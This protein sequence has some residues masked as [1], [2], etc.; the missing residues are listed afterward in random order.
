VATSARQR[1]S[2]VSADLVGLGTFWNEDATSGSRK[3]R[4]QRRDRQRFS[5][6]LAQSGRNFGR[7]SERCVHEQ[8][9][10]VWRAGYVTRAVGSATGRVTTCHG[11]YGRHDAGH[12]QRRVTAPG[13]AGHRAGHGIY[14]AGDSDHGDGERPAGP[15]SG[16][17]GGV[18]RRSRGFLSPAGAFTSPCWLAGGRDKSRSSPR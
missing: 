8:S 6:Y 10:P 5:R 1:G 17:R 2:F 14:G 12:A 3:A 15:D 13:H 11:K 16:I 4:D 9:T 7:A 18:G